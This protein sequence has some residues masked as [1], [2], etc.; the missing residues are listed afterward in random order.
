MEIS[1]VLFALGIAELFYEAEERNALYASTPCQDYAYSGRI[2]PIYR[3]YHHHP[4]YCHGA[5]EEP[6]QAP[7]P[8]P[9][10]KPLVPGLS[11]P[12]FLTLIADEVISRPEEHHLSLLQTHPLSSVT[13]YK[14]E[15]D[16]RGGPR[17]EDDEEDPEEESTPAD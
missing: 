2:A 4:Y 6:E 12:E 17:T 7:P 8:S 11:T 10:Y 15:S 1:N 5:P 3:G 9:N 13:R 16:R 14:P